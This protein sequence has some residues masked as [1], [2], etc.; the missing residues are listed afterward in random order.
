MVWRMIAEEALP[1]R[2][3]LQ[4]HD[5]LVLEVPEREAERL[6]ER[7]KAAMESVARFSIPLVAD[8]KYAKNW[9][10]AH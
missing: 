5:E 7:I 6:A 2:L 10:D 8:A 3:L 9:A 4:V 1:A